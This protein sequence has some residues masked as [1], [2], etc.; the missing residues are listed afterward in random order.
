VGCL[1]LHPQKEP[2]MIE[3]LIV[4]HHG[5]PGTDR[6]LSEDGVKQ[7]RRLAREINR[8]TQGKSIRLLTSTGRCATD[9][10][11]V[12]TQELKLQREQV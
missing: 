10:T 12:L 3:K 5:A 6:R 4:I 11:E 7:I 9:T 2:F 8:L 1:F